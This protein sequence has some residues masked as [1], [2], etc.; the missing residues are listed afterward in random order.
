MKNSPQSVAGA[1]AV[2]LL[3]WLPMAFAEEFGGAVTCAQLQW[4]AE[5]LAA[6]PDVALACRGVFEK[7]EVLYAQAVI[8]VVSVRG[9]TMTFRTHRTD[10]SLGKPRTVNLDKGWR[11]QLDGREYRATQLLKGQQLRVYL[12]QDRFGLAIE[13]NDG[14]DAEE[15]VEIQ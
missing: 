1:M 4:S 12:P 8:E 6:N 15:V 10:G 2:L 3:A 5:V 14:P 13:D 11:V 9:N 7:D